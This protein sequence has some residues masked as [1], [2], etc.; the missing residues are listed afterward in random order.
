MNDSEYPLTVQTFWSLNRFIFGICGLSIV[1]ILNVSAGEINHSFFKHENG[2]K[3]N[4]K[5]EG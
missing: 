5:T 4:R 3:V 1:Y 2:V